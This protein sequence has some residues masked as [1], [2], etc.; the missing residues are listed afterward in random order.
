MTPRDIFS[1]AAAIIA[2]L[3]GG[4]VLVLALSS[5]LGKVWANRI[6]EG[7]KAKYAQAL[8]DLKSRYLRDTEKYKTSLKKSEFIFEKEYQAASEFVALMRSIRP[9]FAHPEMDWYEACDQIAMSFNEHETTL[10]RFLAKHGAVLSEATRGLLSL[11]ISLAADGKFQV[12]PEIIIGPHVN[13][14]AHNFY[15][16]LEE[17]EQA[18]LDIVRDQSRI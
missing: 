6:L 2:S 9:T 4:A 7:D 12:E 18:L 15:T 14:M 3:G 10:E 5:W 13:Q 17:I 16:H 11:C 8:E 1:L